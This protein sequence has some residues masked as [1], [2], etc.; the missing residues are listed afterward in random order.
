MSLLR[1]QPFFKRLKGCTSQKALTQEIKKERAYLRRSYKTI[2]SLKNAY[3]AYRK[4]LKESCYRHPHLPVDQV[5]DAIKKGLR[6]T[7]KEDKAFQRHHKEQVS[8][9]NR[10]L[11]PIHDVDKHIN[12]SIHLLKSGSYLD[13]VLGLS[14]LT[15][16]RTAEIATSAQFKPLSVDQIEFKG[17][18]KVKG[19][20]DIGAYPIPVLH[21]SSL[22]VWHLKRL[23][24]NKPELIGAPQKF[25]DCCSS[26]LHE[27]A[28]KH[29]GFL[30]EE[31]FQPKDL[32]AI[33]AEICFHLYG[34]EEGR[35]VSQ[36]S[37][38]AQILGHGLHDL[39]TAH[40]YLDFYISDERFN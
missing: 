38:Y 15:G 22:L 13:V 39:T 26:N 37:Y 10:N 24:Q 18:L 20:G 11:R 25:H 8:E 23:R 27:R 2:S 29:Y 4:W 3:T 30:Y 12:T 16:R 40:S 17:Q 21:D 35:R 31:D 19:R 14:A 5:E 6:L 28:K 33:Y 36:V 1:I 7:E 9:D 34:E 32:R